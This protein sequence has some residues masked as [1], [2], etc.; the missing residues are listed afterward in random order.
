[1]LT[2]IP[3][4]LVMVWKGSG[5]HVSITDNIPSCGVIC[6]WTSLVAGNDGWGRLSFT[7]DI[8]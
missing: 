1:M 3:K 8:K 7:V 5:L 4:R 6:C 2:E